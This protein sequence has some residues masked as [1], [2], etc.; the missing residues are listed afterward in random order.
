MWPYTGICLILWQEGDLV[1]V[2]TA[3]ID[4]PGIILRIKNRRHH[5]WYDILV[6]GK[7]ESLMHI[8]FEPLEVQVSCV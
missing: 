6:N 4:A 2:F 3:R 5:A 1:K 7:I 8:D